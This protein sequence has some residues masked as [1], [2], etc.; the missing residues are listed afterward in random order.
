VYFNVIKTISGISK[1]SG[2]IFS[3]CLLF[4]DVFGSGDFTNFSV[5]PFLKMRFLYGKIFWKVDF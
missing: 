3:Q 2:K 4:K 5:I 1:F